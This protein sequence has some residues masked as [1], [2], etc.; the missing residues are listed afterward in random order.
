MPEAR[1]G[2]HAPQRI[3]FDPVHTPSSEFEQ[4]PEDEDLGED[5]GLD[6]PASEESQFTGDD[7]DEELSEE[8]RDD[9]TL[10]DLWQAPK[11]AGQKIEPEIRIFKVGGNYLPYISAARYA[12]QYQQ[13][14]PARSA[15]FLDKYLILES[16]AQSFIHF[17]RDWLDHLDAEDEHT[18]IP[19]VCQKDFYQHWPAQ[20]KKIQD[21][22]STIFDYLHI[23]LPNG[24]IIF[25]KNYL[26]QAKQA[27]P[28][29]Y[30]V[31]IEID[32]ILVDNPSITAQELNKV[33]TQRV[34]SW[35]PQWKKWKITDTQAGNYL[36]GR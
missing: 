7:L 24:R 36:K 12:H 29:V 2:K 26:S 30:S 19:A 18:Y 27:G 3:D 34:R 23:A 33:L 6:D 28:S 10:F 20:E 31:H 11:D 8:D 32:R 9:R 16:T 15:R 13:A 1:G 35:N 21:L 5:P 22:A 17:F 14:N 4:S 25:L